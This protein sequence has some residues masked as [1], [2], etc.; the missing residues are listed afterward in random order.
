MPVVLARHGRAAVLQRGAVVRQHGVARVP[1]GPAQ[2][3]GQ[4]AGPAHLVFHLQ[5]AEQDV[6]VG[7]HLRGGWRRWRWSRKGGGEGE[8]RHRGI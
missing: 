2:A 3:P 8:R 5:R 1:R 4:V 7:G 6:V